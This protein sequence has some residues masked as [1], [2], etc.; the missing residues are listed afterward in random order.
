MCVCAC[1]MCLYVSVN[2]V[3]EYCQA[4][5]KESELNKSGMAVVAWKYDENAKLDVHIQILTVSSIYKVG[6]FV[7]DEI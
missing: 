4:H 5:S 6:I 2:V 3:G 7:I 1:A